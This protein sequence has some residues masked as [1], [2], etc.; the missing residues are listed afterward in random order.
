MT[1]AP[2]AVPLG[3]PEALLDLLPLPLLRW[4]L[5]TPLEAPF[6]PEATAATLLAELR[7]GYANP[8]AAALLG[9][10]HPDHL[11]GASLGSVV[12]EAVVLD[13]F[14][15]MARADFREARRA[16]GPAG[17][18]AT[19]TRWPR[20][21]S[22]GP[23]GWWW[24]PPRHGRPGRPRM[25]SGRRCRASSGRARRSAACWSRWRR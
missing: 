7:L 14:S 11:A 13:A 3:A 6:A 23:C 18:E 1:L 9:Q 2:L 21:A 10:G 4:D 16:Q 24:R 22:S 19:G 8:A 12:P 15:A 25:P 17:R 20:R 5:P